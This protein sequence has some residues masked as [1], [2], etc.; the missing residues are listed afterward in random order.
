MKKQIVTLIFCAL[1]VLSAEAMA[2]DESPLVRCC[3]FR[4]RFC[5]EYPRLEE[6]VSEDQMLAAAKP[7]NLSAPIYVGGARYTLNKSDFNPVYSTRVIYR[8]CLIDEPIIINTLVGYEV[9]FPV[10]GDY[11]QNL[12]F[13]INGRSNK[14]MNLA[15]S[16]GT[17]NASDSGNKFVISKQQNTAQSCKNMK[18]KFTFPSN[19]APAT[20]DLTVTISEQL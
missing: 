18:L 9:T 13:D 16:C 19:S 2:F 17:F 5:E 20:I 15:A 6:F 14:S 1:S 10:D 3:D 12:F 7:M 8:P 4:D 11:G